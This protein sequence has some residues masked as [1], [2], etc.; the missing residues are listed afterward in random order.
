MRERVDLT[1]A[2]AYVGEAMR[3]RLETLK[4]LQAVI[5]D[6]GRNIAEPDAVAAELG[7]DPADVDGD[8]ADLLEVAETALYELPLCVEATTTF[9]IV[10]G[11]G[12]PDDRLLIEC[13]TVE[14][15]MRD[16][17]DHADYEI[18][19]ILYRYS[20]SGSAE[21]VLSGE[22]YEVAGRSQGG[23]CQSWPELRLSPLF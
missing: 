12:G 16:E 23:S 5:D 15:P 7:I 20:W 17:R 22:D 3:G 9:E 11:T 21:R 13:E 6:D 2:V 8:G 10:L 18:R 1:D 14:N 4:L 19:R